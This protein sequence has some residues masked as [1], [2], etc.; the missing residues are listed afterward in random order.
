[1]PDPD[2]TPLE[3]TTRST[4]WQTALAMLQEVEP[5]FIPEGARRV[6]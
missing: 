3:R 1:M 5:P 6:S 4:A 2:P